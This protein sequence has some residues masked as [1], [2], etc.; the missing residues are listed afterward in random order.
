M[1]ATKKTVPDTDQPSL[2]AFDSLDRVTLQ[3]QAYEK[4]RKA[5]MGGIFPPGTPITLR[6]AADA[7]GTSAMPIR[8]ALLRLEIEGALVAR[9]GRRTLAIPEMSQ[10]EY[11]ELR[12]IGVVLE[13]MAAERAAT[14]ATDDEIAVIEQSCA[15]MQRAAEDDD[16]GAYVA[17]NW[18]LHR[19]TY[20]ASRFPTLIGMIE[21]RWLRIGPYVELMMP[22]RESMIDSMPNHW[23]LVDAL[24]ARD[25]VA[26]RKAIADDI[27][28][29]AEALIEYLAKPA[30]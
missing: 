20:R 19:G 27:S 10:E 14:R 30:P 21:R 12:D 16:R 13:G 17:A 28:H 3:T 5:V 24:R 1:H 2:P 29:C 11:I 9:D 6:A 23:Q 4:L 22:D 26:A 7:L 15:E 25:P 8:A 18:E